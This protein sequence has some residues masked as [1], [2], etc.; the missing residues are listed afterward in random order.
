M[1]NPAVK[2]GLV[3]LSVI[4]VTTPGVASAQGGCFTQL[5]SCFQAAAFIDSFWYRTW[6]ALDCEIGLV[7]CVRITVFGL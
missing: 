4:Q 5:A 3:A 7:A 1:S 2:R 6:H